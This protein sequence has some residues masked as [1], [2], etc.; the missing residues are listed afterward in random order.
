[1]QE[2]QVLRHEKSDLGTSKRRECSKLQCSYGATVQAAEHEVH[3]QN[4][5]QAQDVAV[6]A[7]HERTTADDVL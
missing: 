3:G 2:W 1:M 6:A 4:A 5:L 7:T